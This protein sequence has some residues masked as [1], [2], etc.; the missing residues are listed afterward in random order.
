LAE[1]KIALVFPAFINDF[2]DD[3][4]KGVPGFNKLFSEYLERASFL[5]GK[6]LLTYSL[7]SD[8]MQLGELSNQFASYIYSCTCADVLLNSGVRPAMIAGYSM[9]IYAALYTASSIRFE[10]G[11]LFIERAYYSILKT[12]PQTRYGMCGVIGLSEKDI[13]EIA[14]LYNLNLA[15]VNK[16]SDY[17]F[18]VAGSSFH[19]NV[20]QLRAKEEGALHTRTMATAVPYHT[21]LLAEAAKELSGTVFTADVQSP[22]IPVISVLKQD[23]ISDAARAREEV[24]N[25]IFNS[26]NWF[27]TQV[28]MCQ[29]GIQ[30]FTE[31]GPSQVLLKNSK[32]MPGSGKF[33]RWD[34]LINKFQ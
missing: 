29:S 14:A 11:L 6:E 2:W 25:N 30:V 27:E 12:L 24:V 9:G 3:P 18:V 10:T 4:S 8:P 21:G 15:I 20:F 28:K 16:N 33:V 17:S 5:T 1:N 7:E 22:V 19:I 26:F 23:L 32:F 31:C 13:T 34:S